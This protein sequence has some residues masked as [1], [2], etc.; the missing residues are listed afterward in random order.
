MTKLIID[1]GF[2]DSL[3]DVRLPDGRIGLDILLDSGNGIVIT[4]AV[5][6]EILLARRSNASEIETWLTQNAPRI[7]G[8]DFGAFV[9]DV[10]QGTHAGENSIKA[11]LTANAASPEFRILTNDSGF[12]KGEINNGLPGQLR[13]PGQEAPPYRGVFD[14]LRAE[15]DAGRM[16]ATELSQ[17]GKA[18]YERFDGANR[19]S[20]LFLDLWKNPNAA[21]PRTL[22]FNLQ[23]ILEN[24]TNVLLI[25]ATAGLLYIALTREAE[26]RGDGSTVAD[27][28]VEYGL[29]L[30]PEQLLGFAG[31]TAADLA[32]YTALGPI[33]WAKKAYELWQNGEDVRSLVHLASE[34]FPTNQ[35]IAAL[36]IAVQALDHVAAGD[37]E[38]LFS[39]M[40]GLLQDDAQD[41]TLSD[42]PYGEILG[43]EQSGGRI[44]EI[45]QVD[46]ADGS[47]SKIFIDS[48]TGKIAR[49]DGYDVDGHRAISV[50][51]SSAPDNG[52]WLSRTQVIDTTG[53]IISTSAQFAKANGSFS[54]GLQSDPVTGDIKVTSATYLGQTFSGGDFGAWLQN[55]QLAFDTQQTSSSAS[56]ITAS[57][58]STF[59]NITA[60][61]TTGYA[62][63]AGTLVGMS[64]AFG[65]DSLALDYLAKRIGLG[66]L[67]D[68]WVTASIGPPPGAVT[69]NINWAAVSTYNP[70]IAQA[71]AALL[72]YYTSSAYQSFVASTIANSLH[73]SRGRI[74]WI[75][76]LV[77]DLDG[78]GITLVPRSQSG[79]HFD[80]NANGT[81]PQ[82]S[83]F[84]AGEG[85]LVFDKNGNGVIDDASEWFGEKFSRNASTPPAGQTGFDALSMLAETGAS[86][87][88]AATSLI[89]AE[90]GAR[91]FDEV[92]VWVDANQ[93]AITDSGE[94]HT[95]TE[96]GIVSIDIETQVVNE[97]VN[98]N[99]VASTGN[100][101]LTNGQRR[102]VSDIGI[103][104]DIATDNA[105]IDPAAALFADVVA[106][107]S[108]SAAKGEA[109]ATAAKIASIDVSFAAQLATLQTWMTNSRG[110]GERPL[111]SIPNPE[112][113]SLAD[114]PQTSDSVLVKGGIYVNQSDAPEK[115]VGALAA[116]SATKAAVLDAAQKIA[117]GAS[118]FSDSQLAAL[119][120]DLTPSA[121]NS[122]E[123]DSK[124]QSASIA[125]AQAI[126]AF[127]AADQAMIDA[128]GLVAAASE[129]LA[130]LVPVNYESAN[131]IANGETFASSLE[132]HFASDTFAGL[133][134]GLEVFAE[135]KEAL[136]NVL[137]A[138]GKASN[139]SN[140]QVSHSGTTTHTDGTNNLV[141]VAEGSQH[142]IASTH[143]DDLA[144]SPISGAALV[145]DFEAG[146]SGD[147]MRFFDVGSTVTIGDNQGGGTRLSYGNQQSAVLIDVD[148][149]QL[150]LTTNISGID[151]VSFSGTHTAGTRTLRGIQPL[152]DGFQHVENI[153]ASDMGDMLI[154]DLGTNTL[155]G[156]AG[157]DTF[158]SYGGNDIIDGR[159][160]NNTLSYA[161][162]PG[163]VSVNLGAGTSSVGDHFT[164]IQNI[165]G[166][167]SG[168]FLTGDASNNRIAGGQGNDTL[169]GGGGNDVYV[170]NIGDGQDLI[171]NGATSPAGPGSKLLLGDG[172]TA[173]SLWLSRQGNDLV[174][175]LIGHADTVTVEDWFGSDDHKLWSISLDSG[176]Q[177][178]S[179]DIAQIVE[180]LADYQNAHPTFDPAT[181]T[182]MPTAISLSGYFN[183]VEN[184]P[185]LPPVRD[186]ALETKDAFLS[187][188]AADAATAALA[189]KSVIQSA[190]SGLQNANVSAVTWMNTE[191][192]LPFPYGYVVGAKAW[193]HNDPNFSGNPLFLDVY[194]PNPLNSHGPVYPYVQ[195]ISNL[196]SSIFYTVRS[197]P[198]QTV[199]TH[200]SSATAIR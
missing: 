119:Q 61:V 20:P 78:G 32:I 13:T 69:S 109:Q 191:K 24:S 146:A 174:I 96:L 38:A 27:I 44:L 182:E 169:V 116:I 128:G 55:T 56:Q 31:Q 199:I 197:A 59:D 127:V 187:N 2:F 183:E 171:R 131:H 153:I 12:Y 4:K 68:R 93:N 148:P 158:Q 48:E 65:V 168:D 77:L 142:I 29:S 130:P 175:Q 159:G 57:L 164:N 9:S 36:D 37:R 160:G 115:V 30:T 47:F 73:L 7:E 41:R 11:Y 193:L 150:D 8:L 51:L 28:A 14:F 112:K 141:L 192:P 125:M 113:I 114:G 176:M 104:A 172:I 107:A 123:A 122:A 66:L 161:W 152:F 177:L 53:S 143:D 21:L 80:L 86:Q 87:F 52:D 92:K 74:E 120:A 134:V 188:H 71:Q 18:I 35:A 137:E 91:Y 1:A 106:G 84:G 145:D 81:T 88:S 162:A 121:T 185:T 39:M 110:Y 180:T 99:Y 149:S 132:A 62:T 135:L 138:L 40:D 117:E 75:P 105:A 17:V 167:A 46:N 194:K 195:E 129:A 64:T 156:G 154:G 90:T 76:P 43:T 157:D 181:A 100:F 190:L 19:M 126:E 83:W 26:A 151:T 5:E 144:F 22:A 60:G 200:G 118:A 102:A 179:T 70:A 101:T 50:D 184:D 173:N 103:T 139:Y 3:A 136:A 63:D 25:T 94:L 170:F 23:R 155:T 186:I 196:T 166:S 89:D 147:V 72:S 54:F 58:N 42:L 189:G 79:A 198:D 140:V 82:V 49:M 178:K 16:S 98:G 85:I 97:V 34:L 67:P 111:Y 10:G 15:S 108:A 133:T 95:L 165:V 33:G 6:Q 45:Y 163:G 124:S